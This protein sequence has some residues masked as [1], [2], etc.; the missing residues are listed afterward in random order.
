[1][2]VLFYIRWRLEA[3]TTFVDI[4][5]QININ[6]NPSE[7]CFPYEFGSSVSRR[8]YVVPDDTNR[9]DVTVAVFGFLTLL[10]FN[11]RFVQNNNTQCR[12]FLSLGYSIWE[13]CLNGPRS[14]LKISG[15]FTGL[16]LFMVI[17]KLLRI[18]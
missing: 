8:G 16:P 17:C 1:M 10:P 14:A 7:K 5:K 2:M 18:K 6:D 9:S 11:V 13:I 15:P 3:G 12:S 4:T